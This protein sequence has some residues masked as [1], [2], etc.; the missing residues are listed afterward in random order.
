M[1]CCGD[2]IAEFKYNNE[3][4]NF[5]HGKF[6]V[7]DDET[8]FN[9][10]NHRSMK[11]L[12]ILKKIKEENDKVVPLLKNK[13][14]ELMKKRDEKPIMI[15]TGNVCGSPCYA[16]NKNILLKCPKCNGNVN[17]EVEN[18]YEMRGRNK[19][20]VEKGICVRFNYNEKVD[21]IDYD[22]NACCKYFDKIDKEKSVH[23]SADIETYDQNL[24]KEIKHVEK[25]MPIHY[26]VIDGE[27]FDFP[28]GLHMKEFFKMNNATFFP[29]DKNR[30]FFFKTIDDIRRAGYQSIGE[31]FWIYYENEREDLGQSLGE[32]GY[33]WIHKVFYFQCSECKYK[34]HII[35]TSPF[36]HRDKSKDAK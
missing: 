27:R 23:W 20:M 26:M 2:L 15:G 11:N 31:V 4:L 25:D 22:F 9:L 3:N 10:Q 34:Y 28:Y 21:Q 17:I 36:M 13:L 24:N 30:I 16:Y 32:Y 19:E 29:F 18:E 33:A 7:S 12:E 8:I 5:M 1:G 35:K 14:D 6:S